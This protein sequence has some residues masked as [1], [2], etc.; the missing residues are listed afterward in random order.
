MSCIYSVGTDVLSVQLTIQNTTKLA[1][2]KEIFPIKIT[3]NVSIVANE[4]WHLK[5]IYFAYIYRSVNAEEQTVDVPFTSLPQSKVYTCLKIALPTL[6]S[7]VKCT[8]V[9]NLLDG[10]L[11]V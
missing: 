7:S 6:W 9:S 8:L 11:M 10:L 5:I 2:A 4:Q 3:F 1:A